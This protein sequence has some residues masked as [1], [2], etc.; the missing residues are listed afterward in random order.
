MTRSSSGFAIS[1]RRR[2]SQSSTLWPW[3][4]TLRTRGAISF[5]FFVSK[6]PG[7]MRISATMSSNSKCGCS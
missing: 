6:P 7:A 5:A 2:T 3:A 1:S 4:K